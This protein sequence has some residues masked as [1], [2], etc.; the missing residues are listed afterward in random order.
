MAQI[1]R[2]VHE[3]GYV[4]VNETT[5]VTGKSFKSPETSGKE[6]RK[7]WCGQDAGRSPASAHPTPLDFDS[8]FH[9]RWNL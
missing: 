7:S 2:N 4:D 9:R 3:E 8:G 5:V 6:Q 1:D